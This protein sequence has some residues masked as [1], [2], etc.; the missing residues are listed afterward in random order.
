[1][2][3]KIYINDVGLEILIDMQQDI[4]DATTYEMLVLKDG[5]EVTWDSSIYED[6]YLR[7]VTEVDDLDV[8]GIYYIQ[9]N[10]VF[11]GGWSGLGETVNF[12]VHPKWR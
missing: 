3:N 2:A 4:S 5:V 6:K 12:T 8:A 11:P 9:G 7:Y 10:F 1:M